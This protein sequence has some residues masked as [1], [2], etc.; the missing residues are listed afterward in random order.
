LIPGISPE[1]DKSNV[2]WQQVLAV[3]YEELGDVLQAQGK[4]PDAL[5]A[6]QNGVGIGTRL[7]DQDKSNSD[8]QRFLFTSCENMGD[9]AL[10]EGDLATA[11]KNYRDELAIS[12]G[13]VGQEPT[14]LSGRTAPLGAGTVLLRF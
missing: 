14:R 7:A 12:E 13:L 11:L 6:Y 4:L 9:V 10:A 1:Q 3:A 8:L 5:L 2:G